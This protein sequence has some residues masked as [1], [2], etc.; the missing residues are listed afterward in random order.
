M[1]NQV[2]VRKVP[3]LIRIFWPEA[4]IAA[5]GRTGASQWPSKD[6]TRVGQWL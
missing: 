6:D 3:R 5:S 4:D 2:A 1:P